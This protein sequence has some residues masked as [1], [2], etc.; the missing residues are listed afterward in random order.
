[1]AQGKRRVGRPKG[2]P[3]TGGRQ[4][5]GKG[6]IKAWQ[7]VKR[8]GR[9]NAL[10]LVERIMWQR[11]DNGDSAGAL[12]A[13]NILLPY[14]FARL[15]SSD[16]RVRHSYEGKSDAELHEEVLALEQRLQLAQTISGEAIEVEPDSE[17]V[18]LSD[19]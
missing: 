14:Q 2:I 10:E 19:D 3:K 13:A 8:M 7:L 12:A 1:M 15:T 5:G 6:K 18:I 16:V 4:K 17:P 11:A 9:E